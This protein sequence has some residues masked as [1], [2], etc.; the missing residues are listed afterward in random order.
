MTEVL[1][2][3]YPA[4]T[5]DASSYDVFISYSH[6]QDAPVAEAL[7]RDLRRFGVPWY[8]H[9]LVPPGSRPSGQRRP[10]RVF[11]DVTNLSAS[12][13]LW[14]DIARA[15]ASSEW[16]V[17]VASPAAARSE[18]VRREV[19]WWLDNRP[20]KRMLIA[21]TD[22]GLT[23]KGDDFDWAQTDAAVPPELS[24][25]FA[26]EPKWIDLR[27]LRPG[28]SAAAKL[29]LGDLVAEFAAP[30]RGLDKDTLVGEHIR[31]RRQTRFT[32]GAAV[33]A[34]AALAVAASAF[35][36]DASYQARQARAGQL[37]AEQQNRHALARQLIAQ[38][39]LLSASDPQLALQLA[40]AGYTILPGAETRAGVFNTLAGTPLEGTV[41][42]SAGFVGS[43]A[44]APHGSLLAVAGP[45][46]V[47]LFDVAVPSRPRLLTTLAQ[48]DQNGLITAV[49]FSPDGRVLATLG[50]GID[51]F[52]VSD[53]AHAVQIGSQL[54]TGPQEV[55]SAMAFSPNG[56][57]MAIV[58]GDI[59]LW[60]ITDSTAPR[61]VSTYPNPEQNDYPPVAFSQDGSLLAVGGGS[62]NLLLLNVADP[63]RPV[64]AGPPLGGHTAAI[65]AV[66]FLPRSHLIAAA[67][68]DDT[69]I[70]WDIT[71]PARPRRVAT[72]GG[73]TDNVTALA[74]S[75]DGKVL[76][77]GSLD[78]TVTL[79]D[80]TDP[81]RPR[82]IGAP[83]P[84]P[85]GVS[86]L[87]ISP[88]GVNRRRLSRLLA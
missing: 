10:L 82:Q 13:G 67:S 32:A 77:A 26:E 12:P 5:Q 47:Q 14:P 63:R 75:G 69:T 79:W 42:A 80:M 33:A 29:Q 53:P 86:A 73:H 3:G 41:R 2:R 71:S 35:A 84:Q 61:Q 62:H 66:A 21:W 59:E 60:D 88:D 76:A 17:L 36:V 16:F 74:Y 57:T 45:G 40:T 56:H 54:D 1:D 85:T 11:R 50:F 83:L 25:K 7:Q 52:D 72:L 30:I 48:P 81:A 8:R 78:S 9:R 34:L 27:S 6:A 23:W 20:V 70:V 31:Q 4:D 37:A 24:G 43:V 18:W 46:S 39:D 22:G 15:L 65:N 49:A 19:A 87:A 51:L 28:V 55:P 58:A 64:A 68:A 38:A 44:Y